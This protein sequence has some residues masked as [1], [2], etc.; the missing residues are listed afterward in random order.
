MFKPGFMKKGL[1]LVFMLILVSL[2]VTACGGSAPEQGSDAESATSTEPIELKVLSAWGTEAEQVNKFMT[3]LLDEINKRSEGRLK[4][5]MFGPETVPGAEQIK[6]VQDGLYDGIYTAG[7]YHPEV[8]MVGSMIMMGKV[9]SIQHAKDSGL[10]DVTRQA[11]QKLGLELITLNPCGGYNIVLKK[12]PAGDLKGLK[13][14]ATSYYEPFVKRLGGS[15]VQMPGNEIYSNLEKGVID[16]ACWPASDIERNK[17]YEVAKCL[18]RPVFGHNISLFMFNG[19]T[20]SKIPADLQDLIVNTSEEVAQ[21]AYEELIE[22]D[23]Q[24]EERLVNEFGMEIYKLSPE[25]IETWYEKAFYQG[26]WEELFA[27][28]D[29]EFSAKIK[30]ITDSLPH[31]FAE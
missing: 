11:Y 5:T 15:T 22:L 31:Y 29:A 26:N 13:V 19:E 21:K 6:A 18:V 3:P 10:V 7:G 14:R 4:I 23:K 12:A 17:I 1:F 8:T 30:E 9:D 24:S 25:Q 16:G 28:K 20:W 2:L 27:G